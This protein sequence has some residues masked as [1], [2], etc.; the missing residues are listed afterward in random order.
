VASAEDGYASAPAT[1]RT[2]GRPLTVEDIKRD[3]EVDAYVTKADEYTRAIGYT[4]HGVRHASLVANIAGNVL[5]RLDPEERA[6]DLAAIAGYL[7]D[8]GN[9]VG[10]VNHEHTGAVLAGRVLARLGMDPV[11]MAI[12]MGAIG[13]HE[14][15]TVSRSARWGRRSSSRTR[16]TCTGRGSATP[17]RR[18][19]ISTIA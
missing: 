2:A 7:H 17:I 3:R 5:R 1:S 6:V 14:E 13:N 19:S 9:V 4:E 18:R 10:R 12:V 11:E 15:E 16:W 8:I